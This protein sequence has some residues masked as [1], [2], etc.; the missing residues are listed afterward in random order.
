MKSARTILALAALA[1]FTAPAAQ[2]GG[3]SCDGSIHIDCD[4]PIRFTDRQVDDARFAITTHNRKVQL[5]LTDR[6]VAMQLSDHVLHKIDRKMRQENED[7]DDDNAL[8]HAIKT[9]VFSGVRELL[10]HSAACDIRDI[11][12]ADY[13]DGEIVLVA[14]NGRHL[15]AKNDFDDENVMS[16][17][18]ASDAREF[19]RQLRD[20]MARVR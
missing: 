4:D 20:Q 8:G 2:A 18:S 3:R 16:D 11:R 15:F 7:A 19:V 6:V 10:D 17:F 9:A 14:R 12:R 5:V 13:R 1:C